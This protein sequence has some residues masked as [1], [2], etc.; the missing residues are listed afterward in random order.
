[1]YLTEIFYII[2]HRSICWTVCPDEHTIH[3][4]RPY[5]LSI[6]IAHNSDY[7]PVCRVS[8]TSCYAKS[9]VFTS[10][11]ANGSSEWIVCR[12]SHTS[13]SGCPFL[14]FCLIA[15]SSYRSTVCPSSHTQLNSEPC[16][17]YHSSQTFCIISDGFHT[18]PFAIIASHTVSRRV[19]DRSVMLAASCSS[20]SSWE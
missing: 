1:M 8:H 4:K 16:F 15:N 14:L 5:G 2:A 19:S 20:D 10:L 13:W 7:R 18:P 3:K 11:I 9:F 12:I 17:M 6:M